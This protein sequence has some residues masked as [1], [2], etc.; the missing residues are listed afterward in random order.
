MSVPRLHR[1]L[2]SDTS[3]RF[4]NIGFYADPASFQAAIQQPVFR[5]AAATIPHRP[6]PALYTVIRST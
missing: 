2:R 3:F 6:H 1:S 5:M 4:V